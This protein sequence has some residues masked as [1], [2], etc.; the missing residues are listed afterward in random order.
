MIK[1]LVTDESKNNSN[2]AAETTTPIL[3]YQKIM[4][5]GVARQTTLPNQQQKLQQQ[6]WNLKSS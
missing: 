1:Q 5:A 3:M 6:C 4:P 2:A